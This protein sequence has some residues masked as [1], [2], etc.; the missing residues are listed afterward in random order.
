M[1]YS[2]KLF[3]SVVL[4]ALCASVE[5]IAQNSEK[6]KVL[7]EVIVSTNKYPQKQS[8]SGKV[9]TVIDAATI[10]RSKGKT[11]GELLNQQVGLTVIGSQN[12]LGTNQDLYLRGAG[13]GY[14]LILVDGLPV[15]D[16]SGASTSF[17]INLIAI[18][19]IERIEILKGG[20][21]SLYGS[22]AVAGVI[23]II[24]LKNS[25]KKLGLSGSLAGGSYDTY[26]AS[27]NAGGQY[28]KTTYGLSWNGTKSN[29]ISAAKQPE[30]AKTA[31]DNDGFKQNNFQ[32]KLG[33]QVGENL[34]LRADLMSNYYKTDLDAGA[35][36]DEKD[37][38]FENKNLLW[39]VG[40]AYQLKNGKL[41]VNFQ[42]TNGQRVYVDDSAHVEAGAFANYSYGYYRGVARF[43]EAYYAHT[44]SDKIKWVLG[45]ENRWQNTDQTYLSISSYGPYESPAIKASTANTSLFSGCTSLNLQD[46]NGFGLEL[47]GR[48]NNHSIYGN[49][50]TY[51]LNPFYWIGDRLKVLATYSSSYKAPSL[52]QLFSPYGNEA[53]KPEVGKTGEIGAQYFSKNHQSYIR[54]V[55]FNRNIKDVIAY[56]SIN[57]DPWGRY[58]NLSQQKDHGFEV[59]AQL[60]IGKAQIKANYTFVDGEVTTEVAGKDTTYANLFRRPKHSVNVNVSYQILKNWSAQLALRSVSKASSG[61][62]D[63]AKVILGNYT[64]LDF[65]TEYQ[66]N[67][68]IKLFFDLKNLT[69]KEFSD[70][71]GYNSRRRNFMAGAVFSIH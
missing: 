33:Q 49:N 26:R 10:Q 4:L 52:Y 53:L 55:Y 44:F 66:I 7:D 29:G 23:N 27:V 51:N 9:V 20:Q 68:T 25:G 37:Y 16:P 35:F 67:S 54:G 65:Y 70:V 47:G 42:Q 22:D 11:V 60:G 43:A 38:T 36:K 64:T 34:T 39:S 2:S 45:V 6:T 12:T 14:T 8:Q 31:F 62:Y 24:T 17:D 48:Y 1:F 41:T 59:D 19:Q 56:I 57:Q 58:V 5:S 15:Y 3:P 28:K 46:F 63:D 50:F 13:A 21:S 18:D 40:G 71:P 30:T 69:D 32:V 61:P